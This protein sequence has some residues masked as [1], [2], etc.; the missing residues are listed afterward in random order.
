MSKFS[1][2][3]APVS[4]QKRGRFSVRYINTYGFTSA[5]GLPVPW[6]PQEPAK[7]WSS[8]KCPM[9]VG[10]EA[11]GSTLQAEGSELKA[12]ASALEVKRHR[13]WER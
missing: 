5:Q 13:P 11:K 6:R 8:Q 2:M 10:Q 9:L 4:A 12:E 1:S 7:A 3:R